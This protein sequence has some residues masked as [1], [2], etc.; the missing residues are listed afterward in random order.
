VVR[1]R[2]AY[3]VQRIAVRKDSVERTAYSVEI[4]KTAWR[5]S[6]GDVKRL[7][8]VTERICVAEMDRDS[9]FVKR[10]SW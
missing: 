5:V 3:G 4:G 1:Q 7:C 10:I 9:W 8:E 6:A 2:V